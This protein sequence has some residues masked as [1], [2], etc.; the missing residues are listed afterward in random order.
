[1]AIL[2]EEAE[3]AAGDA[4]EIVQ[5]IKDMVGISSE[6]PHSKMSPFLSSPDFF[7]VSDVFSALVTGDIDKVNLFF[8]CGWRY[9]CSVCFGQKI[10][11]SNLQQLE[12]KKGIFQH[13]PF[14]KNFAK[15]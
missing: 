1:M 5:D 13:L 10:P 14:G 9:C 2:K 8:C 6:H 4:K 3:G 15:H 12:E 11:T 7:S